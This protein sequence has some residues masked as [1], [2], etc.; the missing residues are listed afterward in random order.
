MKF[1]QHTKRTVAGIAAAAVL[2]TSADCAYFLHPSQR[3]SSGGELDVP[4]VVLDALWLLVG[5][6][7]GVIALAVDFGTGAAYR[8]GGHPVVAMK[9]GTKLMVTAPAV[10]RKTTYAVEFRA[11]DG[12]IVGEFSTTIGPKDAGKKLLF[13]LNRTIERLKARTPVKTDRHMTMELFVDGQLAGSK[14]VDVL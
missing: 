11:S 14:T 3:G 10:R 4:M 9:K 13:D 1:M 12:S 7:P 5:I 8:G 2:F 6:V